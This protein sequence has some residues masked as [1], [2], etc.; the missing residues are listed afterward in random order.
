LKRKPIWTPSKDWS[1]GGLFTLFDEMDEM[2]NGVGP[3]ELSDLTYNV[4]KSSLQNESI[5]AVRQ[6]GRFD[7]IFKG[8]TANK[9]GSKPITTY[10]IN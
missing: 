2:G 4:D 8:K 7:T 10:C 9:N 1:L 3:R 5:E 6:L